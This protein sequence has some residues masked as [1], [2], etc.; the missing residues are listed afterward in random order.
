MS[1]KLKTP[2]RSYGLRAQSQRAGD[3]GLKSGSES[4]NSAVRKQNYQDAKARGVSKR[5][6][7][8][9]GIANRAN[10]NQARKKK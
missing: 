6:A 5:S 4:A 2:Y 10:A 9:R 8:E 3:Q 7:N 1:K